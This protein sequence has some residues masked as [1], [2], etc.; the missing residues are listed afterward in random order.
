MLPNWPAGSLLLSPFLFS[1]FW[2]KPADVGYYNDSE[3]VMF[4]I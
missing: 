1:P 2:A 4:S 3:S